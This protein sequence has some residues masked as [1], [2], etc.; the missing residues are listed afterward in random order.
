MYKDNYMA[1][2]LKMFNN[3]ALSIYVETVLS[4]LIYEIAISIADVDY[5]LS[6]VLC[7]KEC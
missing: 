4:S 6:S 3:S 1:I 7:F 2:S 5:F